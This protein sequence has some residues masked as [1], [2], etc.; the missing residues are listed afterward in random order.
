V[1]PV[2]SF[3]VQ[4]DAVKIRGTYCCDL[5]CIHKTTHDPQSPRLS[6]QIFRRQTA[7]QQVSYNENG[8]I[9]FK[10]PKL[11]KL[12]STGPQN[13]GECLLSCFS[14]VLLVGICFL[15]V[16]GMIFVSTT[17]FLALFSV[18]LERCLATGDFELLPIEGRFLVP[19]RSAASMVLGRSLS[20]PPADFSA[21]TPEPAESAGVKTGSLFWLQASSSSSQVVFSLISALSFG[22]ILGLLSGVVEFELKGDELSRKLMLRFLATMVSV[23]SW[24]GLPGVLLLGR[25]G[26]RFLDDELEQE[27]QVEELDE[28]LAPVAVSGTKR[29]GGPPSWSLS[30]SELDKGFFLKPFEGSSP[31]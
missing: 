5:S 31:N 8:Q 7:R 29:E 1:W 10:T 24:S 2:P 19:K 26:L 18:E 14:F 25:P 15:A 4:S 3:P 12:P 22:L 23:A 30:G 9:F 20:A 28:P 21:Q 16:L 27:E 11:S 6:L 17:N 13:S